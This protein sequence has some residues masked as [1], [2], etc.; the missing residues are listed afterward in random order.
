MSSRIPHRL[1]ASIVG[2]TGEQE[3]GTGYLFPLGKLSFLTVSQGFRVLHAQR[4]LAGPCGMVKAW[5]LEMETCGCLA[6]CVCYCKE[7]LAEG[8]THTHSQEQLAS[9]EKLGCQGSLNQVM[10]EGDG[11]WLLARR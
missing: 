9:E 6:M 4:S 3:D 8:N 11:K 7:D 5:T 2:Q 1:S 10:E